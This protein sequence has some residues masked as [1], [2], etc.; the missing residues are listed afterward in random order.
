MGAVN[1]VAGDSGTLVKLSAVKG[2]YGVSGFAFA[3]RLCDGYQGT[4]VVKGLGH[5]NMHPMNLIP[6]CLFS[7]LL[8]ISGPQESKPLITDAPCC[9]APCRLHISSK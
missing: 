7:G 2:T 4:N 8:E 5:K 9:V 1:Y 3:H 6:C